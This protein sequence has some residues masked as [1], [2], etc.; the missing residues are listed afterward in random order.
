MDID[1]AFR[2]ISDHYNIPIDTVKSIIS[3]YNNSNS[4]DSNSSNTRNYT[5][6]KKSII[7]PFCGVINE[8]CCRAIVY[9]HGLYTQCKTNSASVCGKC[10]KLK[11]GRIENRLKFEKNKFVTPAGKREVP[12]E[13]FMEKMKYS[14][15][16]VRLELEKHNL[17]YDLA[18]ETPVKKQTRG[19]PKKVQIDSSSSS[20]DVEEDDEIEVEL[21][22]VSGT[23]YL[24]TSE[25]VLLDK[26]TYD[27]VGFYKDGYNM[28]LE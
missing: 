6:S 18:Y 11:Y 23:E 17:S 5:D 13:K 22:S 27:I 1:S 20:S 21:I 7:L 25:G 14:V 19:R 16:D 3:D 8:S 15:E 2:L 24:R 28:G 12:Y 4:N 9:N 26:E 10:T